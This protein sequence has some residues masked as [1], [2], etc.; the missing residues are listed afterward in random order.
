ML[1]RSS[2][3][4]VISDPYPGIRAAIRDLTRLEHRRIGFVAHPALGSFSVNERRTAFETIAAEADGAVDP[5]VVSCDSTYESRRTALSNLRGV[6][7]SAVICAYSPDAITM[8]GLLHD[9]AVEIGRDVSVVS[10]D[11][12]EAFRLMTPSVSVISQQ[13]ETMGLQGVAMLLDQDR[14]SVV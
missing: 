7:V 1:F 11:D 2:V 12:I 5:V 13:A 10:F 9:A 6:G 8:I 4:F 14:K 3:P